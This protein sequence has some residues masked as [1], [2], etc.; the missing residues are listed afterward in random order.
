M[1]EEKYQFLEDF[2]VGIKVDS[3]AVL[4]KGMSN[5][6]RDFICNDENLD[7]STRYD[8]DSVWVTF[9]SLL[10]IVVKNEEKHLAL[11]DEYAAN[12]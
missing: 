7:A 6:L 4:A 10:E 2:K 1:K 8:Y 3:P 5:V 11:I 12:N 9:N